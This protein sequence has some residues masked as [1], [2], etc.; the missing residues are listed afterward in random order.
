MPALN[1]LLRHSLYYGAIL[2]AVMTA[3]ILGSLY[4]RP[5]IWIGDATPEVQAMAPPLSE[6]DR[7]AKRILGVLMIGLMFGIVAVSLVALRELAGGVLTYA[8]A[9][10]STFIILMTFNLVDL[11]LI[12]WLI[13]E[14]MRPKSITFPGAESMNIYGGYAHHFYGFLKGTGFSLVAALVVAAVAVLV[15]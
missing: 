11:L 2:S 7:R 13:V 10:I 15:L 14:T 3:F 9:A 12:D 4:W 1:E 5:M 6:G 8:A